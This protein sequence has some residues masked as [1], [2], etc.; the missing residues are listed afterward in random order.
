MREDRFWAPEKPFSHTSHCEGPPTLLSWTWFCFMGHW[1]K[2]KVSFTWVKPV[3][4]YIIPAAEYGPLHLPL[5]SRCS[6]STASSNSALEANKKPLRT[7]D[8]YKQFNKMDTLI[9]P[10]TCSR[11]KQTSVLFFF[12]LKLTYSSEKTSFQ[13]SFRLLISDISEW[14]NYRLYQSLF[15]FFYLETLC[16]HWIVICIWEEYLILFYFK[17][18]QMLI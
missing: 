12:F 6:N 17:W 13:F 3:W 16:K 11:N 2:S 15:A 4:T 1:G 5:C 8:Q 7:M 9:V 14:Q 18:L 10:L